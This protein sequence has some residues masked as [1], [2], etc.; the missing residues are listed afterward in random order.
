MPGVINFGDDP[1][2]KMLRIFKKQVERAGLMYEIKKK[3]YYQKPSVKKILK[4]RE[5]RRRNKK[6]RD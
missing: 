5:A 2:D 3:E 4:S 6:N 1:V